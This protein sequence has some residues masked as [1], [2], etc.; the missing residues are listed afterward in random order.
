LLNGQPIPGATAGTYVPVASGDYSVAVT[1]N[2][3]TVNTPVQFIL[4]TATGPFL[5]QDNSLV[6]PNPAKT[7]L[8][9]AGLRISHLQLYDVAGKEIK[10]WQVNMA[11]PLHTL[12]LPLLPKGV[13]WLRIVQGN[14]LK[15]E[16]I[17]I[18]R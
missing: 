18:E 13:Y 12:T 1:V 8:N 16:K 11:Q 7:E 2:G 10:S 5:V 6:W 4:I 9:V 3:C 15:Y 14:K 17:A